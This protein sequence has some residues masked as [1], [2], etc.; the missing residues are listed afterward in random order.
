MYLATF[1]SCFIDQILS[2]AGILSR[3]S[4]PPQLYHARVPSFF[5]AH[6]YVSMAASKFKRLSSH[7]CS[8][9]AR[10]ADLIAHIAGRLAAG[11]GDICRISFSRQIDLLQAV[12]RTCGLYP[13]QPRYP[14]NAGEMCQS[15]ERS[16]SRR[17]ELRNR[18][19]RHLSTAWMVLLT[20]YQ[21]IPIAM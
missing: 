20:R 1:I 19:R 11:G 14:Q 7:S 17:Q 15:H 3:T 9:T 8:S 16:S 6:M 21:I 2:F 18:Y 13:H 10:H 12:L 4:T 5:V